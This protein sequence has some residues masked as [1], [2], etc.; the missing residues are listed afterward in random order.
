MT[1]EPEYIEEFIS[2][3]L[4]TFESNHLLHTKVL[5]EKESNKLIGFFCLTMTT[6]KLT[7]KYKEDHH[8]YRHGNFSLYP[9]VDIQYF[10]IDKK[11]QKRGLGFTL[12]IHALTT[13]NETV[14]QHVGAS[15]VTLT[16]LDSAVGFYE[17]IGF[18]KHRSR[19][20]NK[21]PMM[22][23]IEEVEEILVKY[24]KDEGNDNR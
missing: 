13:I 21:N 9:A 8:I 12:M 14:H 17:G 1:Q 7:K 10:A 18:E 19:G 5:I 23:T 16:S 4:Q 22:L 24:N 3:N 11:Y 2:S 15:L 20:K 6:V